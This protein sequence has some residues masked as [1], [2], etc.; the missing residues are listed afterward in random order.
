MPSGEFFPSPTSPLPLA[1]GGPSTVATERV[2]PHYDP[3]FS[4]VD[5]GPVGGGRRWLILDGAGPEPNPGPGGLELWYRDDANGAWIGPIGRSG[6]G[7]GA[8]L[9]A[10]MDENIGD[11]DLLP[12]TFPFDPAAVLPATTAGGGSVA[13]ASLLVPDLG[14]SV[15]LGNATLT[16]PAFTA[17]VELDVQAQ[18]IISDAAGGNRVYLAPVTVATIPAGPYAGGVVG[19]LDFVTFPPVIDGTDAFVDTV[20]LRSAAS[21]IY[22]VTILWSFGIDD[23][24]D[25]L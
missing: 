9:Q 14:S 5:P 22:T 25:N 12:V 18:V 21:L 17:A 8:T 13:A 3:A 2:D 23:E 1:D 15:I 19:P 4:G 10:R 7:A 11:H 6:G 20:L 24:G 16:I